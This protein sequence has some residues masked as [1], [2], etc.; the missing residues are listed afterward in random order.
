MRVFKSGL[1]TIIFILTIQ[2]GLVNAQYLRGSTSTKIGLVPGLLKELKTSVSDAKRID[3]Y[4]QLSSIYLFRPDEEKSHL[5]SAMFF[6]NQARAMAR[7]LHLSRKE[8]LAMTLIAGI[9]MERPQRKA[10]LKLL[11]EVRDQSVAEKDYLLASYY[12]GQFFLTGEKNSLLLDS[13]ASHYQKALAT[14]ISQ[15]RT[16][17][18]KLVFLELHNIYQDYGT[19]DYEGLKAHFNKMIALTDR[20]PYLWPQSQIYRTWIGWHVNASNYSEAMALC[21]KGLAAIEKKGDE[22]DRALLYLSIGNIYRLTGKPVQSNSYYLK[23]I[24]SDVD[25]TGINPLFQIVSV[26]CGNYIRM[27]QPDKAQ[28]LLTWYTLKHRN[29]NAEEKSVLNRTWGNIETEMGHYD[30]AE[31]YF[32]E[33]GAI[34]TAAG[35]SPVSSDLWLAKLYLK[36]K[37]GA[38]ALEILKSDE[39]FARSQHVAFLANYLF[40]RAQA[41]SVTG[42]YASALDYL[43]RSKSMTDSIFNMEKERYTQELEFQYETGKKENE[44]R[45]KEENIRFLHQQ[46]QLQEE[47]ANLQLLK[48]EQSDL[49]VKKNDADLK[50]RDAELLLRSKNIKSYKQT[51]ALQLAEL[52]RAKTNR[53]ITIA[54]ILVLTLTTGLIYRQFR[55]KSKANRIIAA[56]NRQLEQLNTEKDW[57]LKEMHH[58]VKNNLQIIISLLES[59]QA[60]DL[61]QGALKALETSK[62]RIF[63]ISLIHQKLYQSSE[64]KTVDM[65][66]YIPELVSYLKDCFLGDQKISFSVDT[67]PVELYVGQAIPLGLIINEAV[68]NAL[69]YAFCNKDSGQIKVSLKKTAES[70]F[71][72]SIAD[73]GQGF[74]VKKQPEKTSSMGM[75]LIRGLA[76]QIGATLQVAQNNGT[77]IT[78]SEINTRNTQQDEHWNN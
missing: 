8:Q 28:K 41:D 15:G 9:Y 59:Q 73:N 65:S 2:S 71:E 68:T 22:R 23:V 31:K 7:S 4:T 47:Q 16:E 17:A 10:G 6:A 37:K 11:K 57:L 74:D 52:A 25:L 55:E 51:T 21:L 30:K 35:L 64:N 44:L 60:G 72:L 39:R 29:A 36:Q 19:K 38:K 53:N 66:C 27:K 24:N 32:I 42:N 45:L 13:C 1:T 46:N 63:A 56:K 18:S 61:D 33:A 58:R 12:F 75:T 78:L 14:Y 3:L 67:D 69:K 76:M 5:D 48:L 20:Y 50:L 40:T 43:F 70:L 54:G 34:A 49:L 26:T 62:N 77:V